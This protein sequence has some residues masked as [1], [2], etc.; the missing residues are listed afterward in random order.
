MRGVRCAIPIFF[1]LFFPFAVVF[2]IGI[3]FIDK[4]IIFTFCARCQPDSADN[5]SVC[6]NAH[7]TANRLNGILLEMLKIALHTDRIVQSSFEHCAI[8]QTNKANHSHI[9]FDAPFQNENFIYSICFVFFVPF[10]TEPDVR[11]ERRLHF[12]RLFM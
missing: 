1:S 3:S 12:I 2:I 10:Q 11:F 9:V 8:A 5:R 6:E 7:P 4:L